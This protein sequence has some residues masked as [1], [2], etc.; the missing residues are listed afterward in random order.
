MNMNSHGAGTNTGGENSCAML[1]DQH[2]GAQICHLV[3][4]MMVTM[5]KTMITVI[6]M[7]MMMTIRMTLTW[8]MTLTE[9]GKRAVFPASS[10]TT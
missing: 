5:E 10:L 1:P 3:N 8:K 9:Q 2:Q 4:I 6:T 7:M